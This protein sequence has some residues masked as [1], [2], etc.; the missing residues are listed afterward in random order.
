MP[1]FSSEVPLF[2][3]GGA[4][5]WQ[6]PEILGMN[7]LPG[8][9]AFT[10]F[11]ADRP[12]TDPLET[13]PWVLPLNGEWA[14]RMA[15]RPEEVD[16][17]WL[18]GAGGGGWERLPVPSNW[19][20][21]GYGFPH[22]TNVQMPFSGQPPFVP[23]ENPTGVYARS[24]QVPEGW[25]GRR[26]VLQ[27]GGAESVLY[28]YLNGRAVGMGKD[29]RL[30]SEFDLTPFLAS[31]GDNHLVLVVVKW[32]DASYIEDQDQWWMGGIFRGVL[33]YTTPEVHL[34]DLGVQAGLAA[35]GRTGLLEVRVHTGAPGGE[36][37]AGTV[38]LQLLDP[39]GRPLW[40]RPLR[41][42]L[43]TESG[44]LAELTGGCRFSLEVPRIHPW[45]DETPALYRAL[46]RLE[47]AAGAMATVVETGFRRIEIDDG[48]LLLNGKVV[49][50]RGV[51]RHEHDPDHG[52]ALP[53]GSAERD[54][55]LMKRLNFNA[56]R[57]SHYPQD[58]RWYLLCDRLGLLVVDEANLEA[59][60][61]H[62]RICRDPRYAP[63]F[64]DRVQRMVLWG[65]NHPSVILWS[66][67]NESG[68]GP[69]HDAAAGWVRHF[70]PSRPLHYEGAVSRGQSRRT[71]EGGH[72][73]T[74][75]ICPMYSSPDEIE[76]WMKGPRDEP[77]RPVI[78]CEYSHAMGNSNGGLEVYMNL[79]ERYHEKGLQ[80]GFIWEWCDH[81]LRQS[82]PDGRSRLA[83]GGDFGDEPNDANFVCDGI[84]GSD[85][86]PHP[87]AAEHHHLA[88]P[89][90]AVKFDA[91][92]GAVTL[93]NRRAF[94]GLDDLTGRW[95]MTRDGVVVAKG[96]LGGLRVPAG[97]E[98]RV[99]LQGWK[100]PARES[101]EL[102]LNLE[103]RLR[104]ATAWAEAGH[105]VARE[106]LQ[107][108]RRAPRLRM[109]GALGSSRVTVEEDGD[110]VLVDW[111]GYRACFGRRSGWLE[112]L[113]VGETPLLAA[114]VTPQLWRAAV[115][116]D[117]LKLWTGQDNK[118][119]GRW[120]ACGLDRVQWRLEQFELEPGKGNRSPRVR[121]VW[122][123]SGRERWEDFRFEQTACFTAEGLLLG[124][125]VAVGGDLPDLPRVGLRVVL[126]PDLGQVRW[127]G[128]GPG[129]NYPDRVAG[130]PV[131]C[132]TLAV[133]DFHV[134]YVMPQENGHRCG[135][136]WVEVQP[137]AGGGPALRCRGDALF[138]FSAGRH[139][140]EE[141][142]QARHA[143]DLAPGGEA[144]LYLDHRHRG[145]GTG[146][147]GPDTFAPHRIEEKA[148][149]FSFLLGIP[150]VV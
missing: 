2:A 3:I 60:A 80:G 99:E 81:G 88:R 149:R 27:V 44:T 1:A 117:G 75:L 33:L 103:F 92:A 30:P 20:L 58:R 52:T 136:R 68:Y 46:L 22:Y 63:A 19:T 62:N 89:V 150:A 144:Y 137:D 6:S 125:A 34:S 143:T 142:F 85:R 140:A 130:S 43:S 123:G 124:H 23:G 47:T 86:D 121:A 83:Y 126:P 127:F 11:P 91:A 79:F 76:A 148:F 14:F 4:P 90:T 118:P 73:G 57:N 50:I 17:A 16:P 67:G 128:H 48:R 25:G 39:R 29:S 51:N 40:K 93:R 59:H 54:A 7:R 87:A 145:V 55:V 82:L 107:I 94:A 66:L 110:L 135:V 15:P 74:D 95:E 97:G 98:A 26:V 31:K 10:P 8:R 5:T 12:P 77:R 105:L 112:G 113:S 147:C 114:A 141:L 72:R 69:N 139:S 70:D 38:E 146:S 61:F 65:R 36:P 71:W 122:R 49:R 53:P 84:V 37:M 102:F 56:V 120:L 119:L 42:E 35:D 41:Q 9:A 78:L 131:G 104:K 13:S 18:K 28:V 64:L 116:N 32:S 24:F 101:G 132:Y 21:L 133:D 129:E 96:R 134:P 111:A 106:Q 108:G 109:P 100:P 45:S 115:D 138:G